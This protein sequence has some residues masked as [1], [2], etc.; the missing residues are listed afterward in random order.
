MRPTPFWFFAGLAVGLP[1]AMF[2]L[3]FMAVGGSPEGEG[4]GAGFLGLI[5]MVLALFCF[6]GFGC[7]AL[8][9]ARPGHPI[10]RVLRSIGLLV[11]GLLALGW[12]ISA[13]ALYGK[14]GAFFF[15]PFGTLLL[16]GATVAFYSLVSGLFPGNQAD[17]SY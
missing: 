15:V 16:V 17:G 4:E 9:V 7:F 8:A 6:V 12:G 13:L 5:V 10:A 14:E 3:L 1:V 11:A 2:V